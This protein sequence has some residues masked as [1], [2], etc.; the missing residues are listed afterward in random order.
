MNKTLATYLIEDQIRVNSV[1]PGLIKT[2]LS[3]PIWKDDE[4]HAK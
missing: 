2:D 3:G 1:A 4:N